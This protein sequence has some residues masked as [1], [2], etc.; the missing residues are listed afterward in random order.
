[1]CVHN[2]RNPKY[3]K[4]KV[5]KLKVEIDNSAIKVGDLIPNL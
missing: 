5:R 3:I 4:Q 1:M 2:K